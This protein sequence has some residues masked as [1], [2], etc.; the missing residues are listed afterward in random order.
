MSDVTMI[1]KTPVQVQTDL[2]SLVRSGDYKGQIAILDIDIDYF[3]HYYDLHGPEQ[4]TEAL[5][6]LSNLLQLT[7]GIKYHTLFAHHDEGSDSW[8]YRNHFLAATF[9]QDP[10]KVGERVRDAAA[11]LNVTLS[12]PTANTK[13]ATTRDGK[14][15]FDPAKLGGVHVGIAE[16][17]GASVDIKKVLRAAM[18]AEEESR[19]LPDRIKY[20]QLL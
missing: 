12:N 17:R 4:E 8:I 3:M 10:L 6:A 9:E 18:D 13:E 5:K 7:P 19:K 11:Q 1:P 14:K 16:Y 2:E 20:V 15:T